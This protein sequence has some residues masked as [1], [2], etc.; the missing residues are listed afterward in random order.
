VLVMIFRR[1]KYMPPDLRITR[2]EQTRIKRKVATLWRAATA[3]VR[4]VSW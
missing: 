2:K 3:S 1:R 4:C